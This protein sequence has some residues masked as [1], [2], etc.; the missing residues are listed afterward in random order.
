MSGG[1]ITSGWAPWVSVSKKAATDD[2]LSSSDR[3]VMLALYTYMNSDT[4]TGYPSRKALRERAKVSEATLSRSIKKLVDAGYV[5]VEE[6]YI[7]DA[8]GNYTGE[9][10]ANNYH[11]INV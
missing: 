1:K 7:K 5:E 2:S 3:S 8:N 9:R 11:M 4:R 10:G 6:V